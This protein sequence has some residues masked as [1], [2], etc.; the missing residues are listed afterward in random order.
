MLGAFCLATKESAIFNPKLKTQL[1]F[2][3]ARESSGYY[4]SM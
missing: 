1:E 2:K 3:V 4:V